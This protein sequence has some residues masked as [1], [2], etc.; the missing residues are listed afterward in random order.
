[1]ALNT[2]VLI[3]L[4]VLEELGKEKEWEGAKWYQ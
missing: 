2:T 3:Q 1:M 4:M